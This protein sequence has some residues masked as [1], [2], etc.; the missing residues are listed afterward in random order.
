[1]G[2]AAEAAAQRVIITND[3]PRSEDPQAIADEI[4]AG[5][6]K[7]D[8]ALVELNRAAAIKMAFEKAQ[9][10]D[11]ILVAGKGH[12]TTQTVGDRVLEFSDR[13]YAAELVSNVA[14]NEGGNA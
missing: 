3:N 13:D 14:A 12:E 7:P 11:W 5:F 2:Q 1:M 4:L 9:P 6:A 10:N 8:S